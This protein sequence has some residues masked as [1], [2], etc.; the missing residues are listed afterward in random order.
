MGIRKTVAALAAGSLVAAAAVALAAPASAVDEAPQL[1]GDVLWFSAVGPLAG[2]TPSTQIL[3][4]SNAANR[5]WATLTTTNACPAESTAMV[6][7]I[8]VP[9]AGVPENDWTQVQMGAQATLKDADGRFYTTTTAQ[10]DRLG[11]SEVIAYQLAHPGTNSYPFLAVCKNGPLTVGHF[12]TMVAISGTDTASLAWAIASPPITGS[13]PVAAATTTTLAAT[14]SGVDLVLGATVSPVAAAGTVTFAEGATTLGSA[15]VAS[16]TASFTVTAPTT[17]DH[18]YTATFTPT[19]PAAYL[20]STASQ[21]VTLGLANG[22]LT[23]TLTVPGAPVEPGALTLAV[24]STPVALTGARDAGNTRVTASGA[25]PQIT[26]TDTRRDDLLTGWRVNVQAADFT[27]TAG[28]VG[29]KYLGWAPAT[30]VMDKLP[31]APLVVQAGA[32]VGSFL[33]DATSTGLGA[34]KTLAQTTTSG[35]GASR[36][37]AALNLAIPASTAEGSYTSTITVTLVGN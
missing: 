31:G 28:T 13:G 32:H 2:Q 37:G 14:A 8:R 19:D 27:G 23:V 25:L 36:L 15:P 3:S 29:A 9:Q 5:P 26:V 20:S 24:P 12:R 4:G 11:K 30:P 17:G 35:R 34:S 10:A 18:T 22:S 16:G 7:Y 1:T 21:S 33:D 6:Q